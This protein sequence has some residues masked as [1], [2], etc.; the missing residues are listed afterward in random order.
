MVNTKFALP[1]YE[2]LERSKNRPVN[3]GLVATLLR[4][5]ISGSLGTGKFYRIVFDFVHGGG[6]TWSYPSNMKEIR[7]EDYD[8][9]IKMFGC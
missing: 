5:E 2:G 3:I 4:D 8:R 7:D 6:H 1:S 9:I